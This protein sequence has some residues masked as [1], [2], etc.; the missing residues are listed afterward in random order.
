[1]ARVRLTTALGT[2]LVTPMARRQTAQAVGGT[3]NRDTSRVHQP[4]IQLLTCRYFRL[5]CE[6]KVTCG[7]IKQTLKG[8]RQI[9]KRSV[10]QQGRYNATGQNRP[11]RLARR[12]NLLHAIVNRQPRG[13]PRY[14][15]LRPAQG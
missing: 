9:S 8:T 12:R 3:L 6:R 13:S 4:L 1:M 2:P 11:R 14:A 15:P 7:L 5:A 10:T